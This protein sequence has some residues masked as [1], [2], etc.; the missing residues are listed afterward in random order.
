MAEILPSDE[1]EELKMNMEKPA[2][3]KAAEIDEFILCHPDIPHLKVNICS[4]HSINEVFYK[5]ISVSKAKKKNKQ[6]TSV[7][8]ES[9]L[10]NK[11]KNIE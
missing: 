11:V 9:E 4:N 2:Y 10:L 7:I 3:E 8:G 1:F 5:I 6:G